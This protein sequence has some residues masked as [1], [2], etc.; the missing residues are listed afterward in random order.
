[1]KIVQ[2]RSAT[3]L[4]DYEGQ[5]L[6]VDPMLSDVGA[7]PGFK[8]KGERKANPL[9]PLPSNAADALGS[10]TAILLTHEHPDHFDTAGRAFAREKSLPVHASALDAPHLRRKG[11]DVRIV[12]EG[13][14][15]FAAEVVPAKHGRGLLGFLLGPVAGYFLSAPGEPS[16]YLVGDAVWGDDVRDAI[17]RHAPDVVVA[18]AGAANF[19]FGADILFSLEELAQ[20]VELAPGKVVLNHLEA[21]DHCPTT[22]AELRA[23]MVA[24]HPTRD[25]LVPEDGEELVFRPTTTSGRDAPSVRSTPKRSRIQKW[26]TSPFSGA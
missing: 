3:I 24:R 6:L 12:E 14:L 5:K 1:M 25:V 17:V 11:F 9:V 7:L 21:L 16:V 8:M 19:G 20:L 4:L 13:S 10:A 18:P 26:M 23:F 2:L 15:G 22:R